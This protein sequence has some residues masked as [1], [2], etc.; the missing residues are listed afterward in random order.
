MPF[1]VNTNGLLFAQYL[2]L[3][4][5]I[6][7]GFFTPFANIVIVGCRRG[8]SL[9]AAFCWRQA[10]DVPGSFRCKDL[11]WTVHS[12]LSDVAPAK[13]GSWRWTIWYYFN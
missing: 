13:V 1:R 2:V 10:A 3:S 8:A 7:L 6:F 5:F 4:W 9:L 11:L 12:L